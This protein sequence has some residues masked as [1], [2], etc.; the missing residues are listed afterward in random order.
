[1]SVRYSGEGTRNNHLWA[2]AEIPRRLTGLAERQFGFR[3][4]RCTLDAIRLVVEIASEAINRTGG[5]SGSMNY[6][7]VI[8]LDIKNAFNSANW[9]LILSALSGLGTPSYLLRIIRSFHDISMAGFLNT[10]QTM[11]LRNTQ[12][13]AEYHKARF[14]TLLC[15]TQ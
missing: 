8:T 15:G 11:D 10:T 7:A 2:V 12:R 13:Q 6:C 4:A 5:A 1:M 3:R 9:T 14:S